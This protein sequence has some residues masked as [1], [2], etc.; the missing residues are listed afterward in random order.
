MSALFTVANYKTLKS[1]DFGF[2]TFGIHLAPHKLSG[3]NVCSDASE[4]CIESCLNLAGMGA[5]STTQKARI[6]KTKD[7][8]KNKDEFLFKLRDETIKAIR[9]AEKVGLVPCFRLNLTSDVK[10][11]RLKF[12]DSNKNIFETFP[13]IQF[14]DYS[15]SYSRLFLDIPNYH[16]T[17]SRSETALNHLQV[18]MA[19]AAKKNVAMVFN[20][21]KG[22]ELPMTYQDVSVIDGDVNDLRFLDPM[23]V[24]VGLRAKGPAK[25]DK[26]NFVIHL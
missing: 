7:L 4:G 16:M 1:K 20:V 2:L 24:I 10:W 13:E 25:K 18:S 14:Y 15:K 8:F 6:E 17:F 22:E 9:K 3:F 12:S 23:G 5:F 11:E 21:K 26:T 19:M